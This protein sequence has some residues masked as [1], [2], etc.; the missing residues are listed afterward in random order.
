MRTSDDYFPF[1]SLDELVFWIMHRVDSS[2]RDGMKGILQML[3]QCVK[4]NF[5]QITKRRYLLL[6]W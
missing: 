6:N 1:E 5:F 4:I 2:T 3:Q